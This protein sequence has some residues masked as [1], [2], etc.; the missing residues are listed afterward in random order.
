MSDASAFAHH[1]VLIDYAVELA[2]CEFEAQ[3]L[4]KVG[5][6]W[7]VHRC[8]SS[9]EVVRVA[10]DAEVV[11]VQT[12]TPW[13]TRKVLAQLPNCRCTIRAGAGYD[14]IDYAAA[15]EMGIMVCNAPTYCTNEVADHAISLLL[16]SIRHTVRL[17][18]AVAADASDRGLV[19]PNRRITG[20]TLGII[21]LGRIGSMVARR[22]AAWDLDILAYDPYVDADHA[23]SLGV[24]L[25]DLETLLERSDFVTI[26]CLLTDETYHLIG[27]EELR[28]AKPE[29]ILVNTARG[30]VIEEA[31]L[32]EALDA[33][34]LW[35]VGL[36]VTETEPLRGDSPLFQYDR[37]TITPHVAAS[38]P[39]SRVDLYRLVCEISAEVVQGRVPPWVVNPE[40]LDHRRA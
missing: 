13:L 19:V 20:S 14:S 8:Q 40:V 2:P 12:T 38:S 27:H 4:A 33:G 18:N 6:S 30:P 16:G 5:A 11:A 28:R 35:A 9:E 17:H 24:T 26:H 32:I 23:R 29:L 25:V 3:A 37:V 34:R 10:A 7:S 1:V 39:Q 21:G 36:D 15:G 31:A 22:M